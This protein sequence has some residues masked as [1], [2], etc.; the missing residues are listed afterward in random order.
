VADL[1]ELQRKLESI[2]ALREIVN[3]MRNLAAVYVRRAEATLEAVRPYADVVETAL[4]VALDR[5]GVGEDDIDE[6]A[7]AAALVFASDQGLCGTYN[8]RVVRAAL[9]FR[10]ADLGSVRFIAVGHR[11]RDLLAQRGAG[12]IFSVGSPSSLEGIKAQAPDL[13]AEILGAYAESGAERMFFVYNLYESMGRFRETVRRVLPPVRGELGRPG[14][15]ALHGGAWA[16]H[17]RL[18]RAGTA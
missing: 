9:Q 2:A 16:N 11:G 15:P 17:S 1:R 6:Q 18:A 3:A 14:A 4:G 13:A 10:E 7:P 8:E 5:A 12:A